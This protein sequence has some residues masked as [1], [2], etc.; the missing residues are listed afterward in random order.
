MVLTVHFA[1]SK[2]TSRPSSPTAAQKY[3]AGH[4]IACSCR[5]PGAV[6]V[7]HDIP[8]NVAIRPSESTAAQNHGAGQEIASPLNG[9]ATESGALHVPAACATAGKAVRKSATISSS[10]PMVGAL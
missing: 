6:G 2:V 9:G 1:P 10:R 8:S 4:E 7:V 5:L 3:V